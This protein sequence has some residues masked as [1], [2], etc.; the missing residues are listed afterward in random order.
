MLREILT[1]VV[2]LIL[3]TLVY[4]VWMWAVRPERMAMAARPGLPWLWLAGA[5]AALLAIV[6][7][8]VTVGFGSSQSGVYV[9]PRYEGGRIVPPHIEPKPAK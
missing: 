1:I 4:V 9:P 5:G 8:V 7:V 6:L 2:P 3:P